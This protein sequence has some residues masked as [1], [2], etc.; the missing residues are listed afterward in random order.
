MSGQVRS[1]KVRSV[2]VR[3]GQVCQ[4]GLGNQTLLYTDRKTLYQIAILPNSYLSSQSVNKSA[5]IIKYSQSA[6]VT[7][8]QSAK[9]SAIKTVSEPVSQPY[10]YTGQLL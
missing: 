10:Q 5:L 2:Q 1:G 4:V 7:D 8:K 6:H 9:L 3:S